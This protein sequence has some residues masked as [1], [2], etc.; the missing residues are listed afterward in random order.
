MAAGAEYLLVV[1]KWFLVALS[2]NALA[3]LDDE[4]GQGILTADPGGRARR[5]LRPACFLTADLPDDATQ[6]SNELIG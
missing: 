4:V 5:E 3:V 6:R 2:R 1:S